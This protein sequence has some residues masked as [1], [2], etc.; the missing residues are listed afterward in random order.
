MTTA[1][2]E[3]QAPTATNLHK[4]SIN[5]TTGNGNHAPAGNRIHSTG[6]SGHAQTAAPNKE[7]SA[8]D[9]TVNASEIE[10]DPVTHLPFLKNIHFDDFAIAA[11]L[12]QRLGAA[13]F[14]T[15]TPVQAKAIPPALEGRDIL[16]TASTGTGK[17]LSFLIPMIE[18]M[19]RN[20]LRVEK[21]KRAPIRALILLPTRELA[22]QVL[23]AYGKLMPN[24][25]HDAVLVC[26]G[27]SENTQLDQ[28]ARGPRM[29]V[30]TPGRLED[31]LRRR[32]VSLNHV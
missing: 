31:Y 2:L 3:P 10:I 26:G 29:V 24:A 23:E 21:G 7:S 4:P 19:D 28:L 12:K 17:T 15:P 22:M 9:A 11:A 18:H 1:T 30:A 13:G 27:L 32:E 8:H 6:H 20:P 14:R 5:H 25:K 16:A